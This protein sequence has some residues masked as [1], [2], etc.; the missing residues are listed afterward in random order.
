MRKAAWPTFKKRAKDTDYP[1]N[2]S[3]T[4]QSVRLAS[5]PA[6]RDEAAGGFLQGGATPPGGSPV[7]Q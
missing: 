4:L 7:V 3:W 2:R 5:C 6:R 1:R